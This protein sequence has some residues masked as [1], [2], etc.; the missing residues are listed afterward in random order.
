M[1]Q[2]EAKLRITNYYDHPTD[3]RYTVFHYYK[4]VQAQAFEDLLI[5][6]NIRYEKYIE[7]EE[8]RIILFAIPKTNYKQCVKYNFIAIG[9]HRKPFIPNKLLGTLLVIFVTL[10]ILLAVFSY[11][12]NN[13]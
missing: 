7:D 13:V 4:N 3:N 1:D 5:E 2:L 6:N 10:I 8:K 11:Y 12:K 9:M